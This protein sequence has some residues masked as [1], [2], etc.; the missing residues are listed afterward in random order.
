MGVNIQKS[1]YLKPNQ[2]QIKQEIMEG[3]FDVIKTKLMA[4]SEILDSQSTTDIVFSCLVMMAREILVDMIMSTGH[5]T[6]YLSGIVM[7]FNAAVCNSVQE[8]VERFLKVEG[9]MH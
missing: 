4:N 5:P 1:D 8:S 9:E 2:K 3:I 6:Q 7:Q